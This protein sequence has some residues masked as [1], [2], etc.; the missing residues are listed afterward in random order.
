MQSNSAAGEN[1]I[2]GELLSTVFQVKRIFV[3][4]MH[5]QRPADLSE[6]Q[7]RT[8]G[9]L[10]RH[11]GASLSQVAN[12]LDLAL[13]TASK[14]VDGLVK[15]ELV[16]REE[17]LN[18]RRRVVLRVTDLGKSAFKTAR[19][20]TNARLAEMLGALTPDERAMIVSTLQIMRRVFAPEKEIG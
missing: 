6:P 19:R 2:V 9:F 15:R 5:N 13:P 8:V 4:E 14:I 7:F 3:R 17:D 18:D 1:E 20:H 11:E 10:A 16:V 12:H